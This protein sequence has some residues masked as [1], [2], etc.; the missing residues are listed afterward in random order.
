MIKEFLKIAGV[1][2]E[3]Q[4]YSK[5]P[6]E[7]AFFKAHPEA[8]HLKSFK[9]GGEMKKLEQLTSFDNPPQAQDGTDLLGLNSGT[10]LGANPVGAFD[11]SMGTVKQSVP[12]PPGGIAPGMYKVDDFNRQGIQNYIS[13]IKNQGTTSKPGFLDKIGGPQ[14][15]IGIAGSLLGGFQDLR[16]EKKARKDAERQARVSDVTLQASMSRPREVIK[17]QYVRP[18]DL[19]V[20]PDELYPP[21]GTGTEVLGSAQDGAIINQIGGNPTEIQNTYNP[22][23]IYSNLGYEPIDDSDQ[24]KQFRKGGVKKAEFGLSSND[25]SAINNIGGAVGGYIGGN[26]AGSNIGGTLGNVA[27]TIIGGPI[28]GAIGNFLG[29]A[30]GG[31]IDPNQRKIKAANEKIRRNMELSGFYSGAQAL[32]GQYSNIMKDGGSVDDND[33]EWISHTW[34]PQVITKFGDVDVSQIHSIATEGMDTLRTGGRITQNNMYETDQFNFGGELQ[35][36]WGGHAKPISYNPYLPGTGETVMFKG[37][38]HEESDRKGR[39]GIGVKYGNDGNYSPYME[40]GKDGIEG[41]TDVEVE[42]GEPAS[43]MIDPETGEKN[44]VVFGNLKINNKSA[45][46]I[47]DP[48]AK[49]KKFKHYVKG[50]SEKEAKLGKTL[51]KTSEGMSELQTY[52]PFDTLSLNAFNA[53]RIGAEMQL[54]DIAN[55]KNNA[56]IIQNSINE[57]AE[58]HGLDADAL[59]RGKAKESKESM[60]QAKWGKQIKKAQ[61][62]Q[63]VSKE[64]GR[65]KTLSSRFEDTKKQALELLQKKYPGKKVEIVEQ[66]GERHIGTQRGLKATGASK[67]DVSIHNLGGAKDLMIKID[68][69]EISD[70]NVYRET[71]HKAATDNGLFN[72]NWEKDPQHITAVKEGKGHDA[73]KTLMKNYPELKESPYYK[74]TIDFLKSGAANNKLTQQ[75][76]NAYKDLTGSDISKLTPYQMTPEETEAARKSVN[77][78]EREGDYTVPPPPP[79]SIEETP[80][81]PDLEIPEV[82]GQPPTTTIYT[83]IPPKKRFDWLQGLN[84]LTPYLYSGY[85]GGMPDLYPEMM[86]LSMNPLEAVKTQQ[87]QPLLETPYDISLQDQLNEVTASSRAAQRMAGGDPSALAQIVGAEQAA[88]QKIQAEQ[89]RLNQAERAGVYGKNRQTLMNTQLQN[90]GLL[91]DQQEKQEK[92]KA[93]TKATALEAISSMSDKIAKRRLED[94]TIRLYENMFPNYRLTSDGRLVPKGLTFINTP[95]LGVGSLAIGKETKTTGPTVVSGGYTEIPGTTADQT[96]LQPISQQSS[97]TVQPINKSYAQTQNYLWG[98]SGD[99]TQSPVIGGYVPQQ[100]QG[101]GTEQAAPAKK[102]GGKVNKK[103]FKNS[104]VVKALK[105]I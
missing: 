31:M 37:N 26:N 68:G 50:L 38:S 39:T 2:N 69:K 96:A 81:P 17:H 66:S 3:K 93:I 77:Y 46:F 23:T 19:M 52:T 62:G 80:P 74:E 18:D 85:Q 63:E 40:Y 34:Q 90:L 16:A 8:K 88:K 22:G 105:F 47:G 15:A 60:E 42:R 97:A 54:K 101:M 45:Q 5:Y 83:T 51:N 56:S 33:Y 61:D 78:I 9:K 20:N 12:K 82:P 86:A 6:S 91:S 57:T 70:K 76:I 67:T 41:K 21:Y 99:I 89:F 53:N 7:A 100:I 28:G 79:P 58:E 35:T 1:K 103:H 55:K 75:E 104:S 65:K 44:M 94:K 36:T 87:I 32:Q 25:M 92:A 64:E 102:A 95:D 11:W 43:E 29:S 84:T 71:L 72:L 59:A 10:P 13:N 24:V 49:N 27:G 4:F 73:F 48:N 30:V 98:T 14:G